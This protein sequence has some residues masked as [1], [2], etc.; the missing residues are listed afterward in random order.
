M[1]QYFGKSR[2]DDTLF[3]DSEELNHIKNVMRMKENDEVIIA[4][5]GK[6]Y[7]CALNKDFLSGKIKSVF[8]SEEKTGN[9]LVYVPLLNDEKMSFIFQHGTELGVNKFVVVEYEHCKYKLPKKDYEKKLKRWNKVLKEAAEQSYR[10]SK[11][12]LDSIINPKDIDSTASVNIVCSLDKD[13]VKHICKVLTIKNCND[14]I[15]LVFGPEGGLSKSEENELEAKNYI[16]TSLGDTVLRTETV[17]LMVASI[18]RYLKD[19]E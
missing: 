13:N 3:L 4:Y 8:K 16:K 5:E 9:L 10:L 12:I 17:P 6:S 19:S 14:T 1:Q 18:I 11:P 7:I 2:T 15:N